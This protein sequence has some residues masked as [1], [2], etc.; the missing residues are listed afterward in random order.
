MAVTFTFVVAFAVSVIVDDPMATE[1]TVGAA[2]PTTTWLVMLAEKTVVDTAPAR[3]KIAIPIKSRC[4]IK[5][6][7][8]LMNIDSL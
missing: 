2:L 8:R 6:C 7:D 1:L 5:A 4:L 3:N